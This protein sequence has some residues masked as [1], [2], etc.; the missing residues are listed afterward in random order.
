MYICV[1]NA[2]SEE[3]LKSVSDLG[4]SGQEAI[5]HLG[6]GSGCG[7]CVSEAL[8]SLNKVPSQAHGPTSPSKVKS[9]KG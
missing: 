2:I 6:I 8:E 7:L 1:C 4:L 9:T 5:K 3:K